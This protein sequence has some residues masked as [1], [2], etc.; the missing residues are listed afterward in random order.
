MYW[1]YF[2]CTKFIRIEYTRKSEI[3]EMLEIQAEVSK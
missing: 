3:Y 1:L 2:E